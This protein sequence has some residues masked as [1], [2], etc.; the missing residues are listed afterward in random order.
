MLC[1]NKLY[2]FNLSSAKF[3]AMRNSLVN[4]MENQR[5][6]L[7]RRY[8]KMYKAKLG[9]EGTYLM[10]SLVLT[11]FFRVRWELSQHTRRSMFPRDVILG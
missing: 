10:L 6:P 2:V 7:F 4:D 11:S 5:N 8:V 3:D 9:P 1:W